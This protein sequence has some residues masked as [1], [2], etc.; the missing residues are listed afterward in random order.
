MAKNPLPTKEERRAEFER[1]AELYPEDAKRWRP[2]LFPAPR[3]EP[4]PKPVESTEEFLARMLWGRK[5]AER[6]LAEALRNSRTG[7]QGS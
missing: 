1:W 7:R 5:D 2:I 3:P 6:L 4:P